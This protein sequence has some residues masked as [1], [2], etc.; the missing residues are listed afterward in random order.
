M[1]RQNF[2]GYLIAAKS[3]AALLCLAGKGVAKY[4]YKQNFKITQG[5]RIKGYNLFKSIW[6]EDPSYLEIW[7]AFCCGYR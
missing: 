3:A 6:F 1:F 2:I 7:W 5:N 4:F